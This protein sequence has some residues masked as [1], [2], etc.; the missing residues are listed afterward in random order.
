MTVPRKRFSG[1]LDQL[2]QIVALTGVAGVWE[3]MPTGYWRYRAETGA[4]LNWWETGT[5]NFQGPAA[6]ASDFKQVLRSAVCG[7]RLLEGPR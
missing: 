1:P 7:Q 4:I 3:R 2:Q 5:F 6:A